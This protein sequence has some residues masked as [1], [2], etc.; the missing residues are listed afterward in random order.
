MT[1]FKVGDRVKVLE[2]NNYG[3]VTGYAYIE[4]QSAHDST[5]DG[6]KAWRVSRYERAG[7]SP[8]TQQTV[9]EDRLEL[10]NVYEVGTRVSGTCVID[11]E[12][13]AEGTI[14]RQEGNFWWVKGT[15]IWATEHKL[16]AD[17][18]TIIEEKAEM[19]RFAVGDTVWY[20]SEDEGNAVKATVVEDDHTNL[21]YRV[22]WV[23]ED[24][25][26]MDDWAYAKELRPYI[27]P[28]QPV[29]KVG[30][31]IAIDPNNTMSAGGAEGKITQIMGDKIYYEITKQG[32]KD[33]QQQAKRVGIGQW[34]RK[35]FVTPV[36]EPVVNQEVWVQKRVP[37]GEW[38][39]REQF[40]TV[41]KAQES[42]S[43]RI[44]PETSNP[45]RSYRIII[46]E[47]KVVETVVLT[48]TR[49]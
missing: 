14:I 37:G 21:P 44:R 43:Y 20:T 19:G 38:V 4:S 3:A 6:R 33:A 9:P 17:T 34:T 10:A 18:I 22:E 45:Q 25:D 23:D 48:L 13:Q 40:A 29:F 1:Q 49:E 24:G 28:T 36:T 15:D 5:T 12:H 8:A 11:G 47:T 31:I 42:V 26:E 27:E 46:R 7:Y 41:A 2:G 30:D 16:K 35:E 32:G 39:D